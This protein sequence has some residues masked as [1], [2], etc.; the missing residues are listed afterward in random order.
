MEQPIT[1]QDKELIVKYFGEA[2]EQLSPTDF[3]RQLKTLR[4]KYHPDRFEQFEDET[5]REMATERFQSIERLAAKVE[6][7]FQ[8]TLQPQ[9]SGAASRSSTAYQQAGAVFGARKMKI[10]I[11]TADKELKYD[12][13]GTFYKWLQCGETFSIPNTGAKIIMDEEQR[14]NRIG[15]Q[16]II[17]IY[18]TF[19]EEDVVEDIVSWLHDRI[20][21]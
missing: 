4:Q 2:L 11:K 3:K 8:G 1:P 16:E 5:V 6:A 9:S 19:T 12:L 18:L 13:F 20:Q 15:Y 7:F 17:R 21:E 14:G 10:E